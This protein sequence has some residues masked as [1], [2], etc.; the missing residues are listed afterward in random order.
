[1]IHL[2]L[3]GI[4][5][6]VVLTTLGLIMGFVVF[7]PVIDMKVKESVQLLEDSDQYYRWEALPQALDFKV[8]FFNVT[9][10]DEIQNGGKPRVAEVGPYIYS[11]YR[12]KHNVQFS[13][14]KTTITY[15]QTQK[16][17]FNAEA[18]APRKQNDKIILLNMVMNT[19][20]QT[21]ESQIKDTLV[22]IRSGVNNTLESIPLVSV[23]KRI[24]ERTTPLQS[25][26]QRAETESTANLG[27]INGELNRVFNRPDSMFVKTTPKEFLFDGIP[28]CIKPVIGIAAIICKQIA[29][30]KSNT[31]TQFDDGSLKFALFNY[32]NNSHDGVFIVNTGY[33]DPLKTGKIEFWNGHSSL[34][35][36][37]NNPGGSTSICNMINGTDASSFPPFRKRDEDLFIFSSDICRSVKLV[38]YKEGEYRN[39]P[40]F[41]YRTLFLN[42]IGQEYGNECFCINQIPKAIVQKNGCLFRGALDLTSCLNANIIATNPHFLGASPEYTSLID[43]F[44]PDFRKHQILIDVEPHTGI[45]L[46]GGKRI[47]FNMFLRKVD[48]ISL[49]KNL[50]TTLFPVVWI[51]EGIELNDEMVNLVN[52]S[53]INVLFYL[54]LVQW[55]SVVIG[56]LLGVS[57]T[58]WF[59]IKKKKLRSQSVEPIFMI[60]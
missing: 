22:D 4:I 13:D 45:P 16:Y 56:C 34:K 27:F 21:L 7:P 23:V 37:L 15:T 51:D 43:G 1:M 55:G 12:R 44:E 11:Q 40:S 32:K 50:K 10:V 38:Y 54:D 29:D 8:Y 2:S 3:F 52:K 60:K 28:F 58:V 9:N 48:S 59:L 5:G 49:T 47:Q 46:R 41:Q 57:C 36:W 26:L 18:S 31:V 24:I 14:D 25:I 30:A 53:L 33:R 39:I 20:F 35:N 6:G 42:Q 17:Y 19:V